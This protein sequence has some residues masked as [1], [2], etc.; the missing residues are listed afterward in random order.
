ML[1]MSGSKPLTF[2]RRP[3]RGVSSSRARAG[4]GGAQGADEAGEED[5]PGGLVLDPVRVW[6]DSREPGRRVEDGRVVDDAETRTP[7]RIGIV[8][9]PERVQRSGGLV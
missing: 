3:E 9:A 6:D 8:G 5:R 7:G 2:H 4:G 1:T